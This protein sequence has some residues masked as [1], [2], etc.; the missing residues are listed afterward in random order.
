MVRW[1]DGV[2]W[3]AHEAPVQPAVQ[4]AVQVPAQQAVQPATP[5]SAPGWYPT[6]DGRL[7]WWDGTRWTGMRVKDGEPG[8]DWATTEQPTLAWVFGGVFL[9]LALAQFSLAALGGLPP[10]NGVLMLAIAVL[11]FAIAV[12]GA[13]V[14][15]IPVPH[16]TAPVVIDA[17]RPLPGEQEGI[18]AGWY[19]V[20]SRTT[21]WWT[22]TRW[23]QYTGTQHGL[24]PTFH[25]ARGFRNY[26]IVCWVIA[27]IGVI[28]ALVGIVM[29]VVVGDDTV[30]F[31]V[32][33]VVL[34]G[35]ILFAVLSGV[36]L[37]VS[38][39]QRRLLLLPEHPPKAP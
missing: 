24:R 28:A 21:R 13:K 33:L 18:G 39:V 27:G 14:R 1:W 10:V 9:A 38:G 34:I 26:L 25:G 20:G 23:S 7:R 37:L 36:L 4:Q 3:T 31:A 32:G 19:P 29:L 17:V 22:G 8:I 6:A 2:Q 12:Q 30:G 5:Q 15:R 35:G 16:G 11:W